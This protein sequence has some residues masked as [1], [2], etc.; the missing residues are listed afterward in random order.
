MRAYALD[1]DDPRSI[2]DRYIAIQKVGQGGM[3]RVFRAHDKILDREVA[4]K[5]L[6]RELCDDHF[7]RRFQQE[8]RAASQVKHPNIL[9]VMDF[10]LLESH[11][12][13]MV[14][15]WI[16]GESLDERL[17]RLGQLTPLEALHITVQI[18]RAMEHAHRNKIIHRD[19]KPANI[20]LRK[21]ER[22]ERALILDFGIAKIETDCCENDHVDGMLT[23]AGQI[24]GSPTCMSP[25]QVRGEALDR[26]ADI[27][28]LGC[29]LFWM[30]AGRPPFIGDSSMSTMTLHLTQPVPRLSDYTAAELPG[31]L[32]ELLEKA[33]AKDV[34]DRFS[35]MLEFSN[36]I[37]NLEFKSLKETLAAQEDSPT[38]PARTGTGI[39]I[40]TRAKLG[41]LTFVTCILAFGALV[42]LFIL[43]PAAQDK[44][45]DA[46]RKEKY[47]PPAKL[48]DVNLFSMTD[49]N[50][51]D[52]GF[53]RQ[54]MAAR[55]LSKHDY[56]TLSEKTTA[57]EMRET[58]RMKPRAFQVNFYYTKITPEIV[59]L[60][61][62][63]TNLSYLRFQQV[64]ITPDLQLR[65]CRIKHLTSIK[66]VK[67]PITVDALKEL[68]RNKNLTDLQLY[69]AQLTDE[70]TLQIIAMKNLDTLHLNG[71]GPFSEKAVSQI[72]TLKKLSSLHMERCHLKDADLEWIS[73]LSNL[74]VLALRGNGPFS[75]TALKNLSK[76][77]ALRELRMEETGLDNAGMFELSKLRGLTLLE[78]S[79]NPKINLGALQY[80]YGRKTLKIAV[81]G[82]G[83]NLKKL[84][85][86]SEEYGGL[87]LLST[88]RNN[89]FS[90]P[91]KGQSSSGNRFENKSSDL[92]TL[93]M[94]N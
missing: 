28:A 87:T 35:S 74:E 33:L 62:K 89:G 11:Q 6:N 81:G 17:E 48:E 38:S 83:V 64:S 1:D 44:V 7:V 50:I 32:E 85:K 9:C 46:L 47:V 72:S 90:V 15:E 63:T 70:A 52:E 12:P 94:G 59:E 27:Y 22:G 57:A 77:K 49:D 82:T 21:T 76:M 53:D 86:I 10:G 39:T 42:W 78:V 2:A 34:D 30:L 5:L 80:F 36:A 55:N 69:D 88:R 25:E 60:L 45:S 91:S 92:E 24:I 8:A 51:V 93:L 16:S 65:I 4:I 67:N 13:Y 66:F 73:T 54:Y 3:G 79:K 56:F 41:I 75:P 61:E 40:S 18:A 19:L 29:V 23:I 43:V 26:R 37:E 31:G 58:I 14:M 84:Y 71:N 20:M 68:K